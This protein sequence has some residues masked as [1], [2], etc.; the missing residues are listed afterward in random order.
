MKRQR[1]I[2]RRDFMKTGAVAAGGLL[3][4]FAVPAVGNRLQS[5]VSL[6]ATLT[7]NAF[8]HI[9]E[10]DTIQIILSKV[11]MGQGI[12]TTLPMLI[13][14]ELDCDWK[15]IT[16]VHS[17]PGREYADPVWGQSTGG[18]NSTSSEFER[19]RQVGAIARTMLVEAAA[20]ELGVKRSDCRTENSFVIVGNKRIRYG[21]V[22]TEASKLRV[23]V[24]KLRESKEWKYIGKSQPRLDSPDKVNGRATYGL[25]IHFP[26][27]LTAV[28][29]HAPVFGAKVTSFDAT[30]AKGITGVRDIVQIPTG[31]A[32]IADH[33]WAA[34]Q[35]RDAL[36][37]AWDLGV[38]A[39]IDSNALLEQYRKIA[40]TEGLRSQQKG[41][42]AAAL[43]RA[44]KTIDAE[45]S[46]PYVAH[47]PMEPL[48]CTV[49][50]EG[51]RCEVWAGNQSPL[52]YQ[53][54]I[55]E[56]LGLEPEKVTLHTPFVGGSFGR[57]A[58]FDA[59]WIVEALQIAKASG[60][61]IKLI[62]SR[63]DDIQGGYYRPAYL[64]R[65]IVGIDNEGLPMAWHHTIV[66]QSVFENTP[67]ASLI[68]SNGID[69]STVDGVNGSPYLD[70]VADHVVALHTTT[71]GV[72]V[73]SWRSVG[74]T[75]TAFVMET[76]VDELAAV[77]GKDP[78]EYRRMLLKDHPRHLAVLNLAAEK[79]GWEKPLPKGRYRGIAVHA[80]MGSYVSQVVELSVDAR[81]I[82]V[83]RVV[84][85]ID[86]G[87]AVNPDGV[88]AQME[89][90]IIFGLTAALYG[91]ITLVQGRVKQTNFNN[92]RMLRMQETPAIEVYILPST[93]KMSGAGEPGVP[94][95]APALVNALFAATGKRLRRLP[96]RINESTSAY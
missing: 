22:A 1:I 6:S 95:I 80:A 69:Y 82:H 71:V 28:V 79:A 89:G 12:W 21:E 75:H 7:P 65:A 33:Y 35:G 29:A 90:G 34:R 30:L 61:F 46:V 62:W 54:I 86:C 58:S 49:K 91:E 23:P 18:S 78:V 32:V 72:P 15:K 81:K 17:L 38:N 76:L 67:L 2:N 9:D 74:N 63:E 56:V 50:I 10:D 31:V 83:H 94:P 36:K 4:S 96:V 11:E 26:G 87:L 25:D 16:V 27:L 70:F 3:V 19:Y 55:A 52:L 13:A 77:A 14:E 41:D 66:G 37:V 84:C 85:A 42:V 59:D 93:G 47:A 88:R 43:K 68:T 64:H 53:S 45:F 40:T 24:V 57:K 39:T 5:E 51:D 73:L 48:N 60:K 44:V 20:K 92:Y 8:L